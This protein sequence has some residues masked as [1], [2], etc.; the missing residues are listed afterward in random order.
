[1]NSVAS[2]STKCACAVAARAASY[3]PGDYSFV[4][5]AWERE[6]LQDAYQAVTV[7]D[8]WEFM[9]KE[10]PPKDQGYMFWNSAEV[11][12]ISQA[13]KYQGHSGGS[14]AITMRHM[15]A[16]AKNGWEDYVIDYFSKED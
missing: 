14:F 1:M 9:R 15:Q 13:M 5:R 12:K 16:V 2:R 3:K 11:D 10:E 6:M 7:T 8:S 4:K